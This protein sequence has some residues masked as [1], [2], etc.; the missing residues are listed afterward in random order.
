MIGG[1]ASIEF[2]GKVADSLEL[3]R[4]KS[5][6]NTFSILHLK[7]LIVFFCGGV[8]G[9]GVKSFPL[10]VTTCYSIPPLKGVLVT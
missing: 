2:R 8:K 7:I 4:G 6:P 1:I 9:E 5:L 10:V 3:F